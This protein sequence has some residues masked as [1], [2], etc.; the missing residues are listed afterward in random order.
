MPTPEKTACPSCNEVG[1]LVV[2]VV[3]VTA[4]PA[5]HSLAGMQLKLTAREALRWRCKGCGASGPAEV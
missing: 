5:S 3:L 2:E 4:Q 1:G